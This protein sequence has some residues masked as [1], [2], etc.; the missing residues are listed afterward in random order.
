MILLR[1]FGSIL[2]LWRSDS[3]DALIPLTKNESYGMETPLGCENANRWAFS[4]REALPK[5][6]VKAKNNLALVAQR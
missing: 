6:R 1:D 3:A 2:P 5:V 4:E